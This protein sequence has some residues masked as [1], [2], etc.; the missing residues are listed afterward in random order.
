MRKKPMM[1]VKVPVKAMIE[2]L[3]S[4]Y[5]KGANYV[6]ISGFSNQLQDEITVTV[7]ANYVEGYKEE[8]VLTD[9][10]LNQLI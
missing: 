6:D 5:D 2:L 10:A 9:E 3:V 4:L 7:R 1:L 8:E